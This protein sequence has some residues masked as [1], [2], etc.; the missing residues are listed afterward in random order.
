VL[1]VGGPNLLKIKLL[2]RDKIVTLRLIGVGS[3]RNRERVKHLSPDVLSYIEKNRLWEASRHYVQRALQDKV[4]EVW[5]RRGDRYDEK[6]RL[7]GYV[8]IPS[9]FEERV[10]L[11]GEI[12]KNGLGFVIRDCVHVTFAR[13]KQLEDEAKKN[14]RGMW[15][16]L[17]LGPISSLVR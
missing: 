3:P 10:D 13:Y 2:G 16:A 12:I 6:N 4:V 17:S 11:N 15:K 7:L 5:S 1:E 14:R 8:V 9:D